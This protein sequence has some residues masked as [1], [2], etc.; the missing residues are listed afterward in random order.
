MI[1]ELVS[2]SLKHAF[3][4]DRNGEIR[5]SLKPVPDRRIELRVSD[6]G[7]GLPSTVDIQET[8]SLGLRLVRILAAQIDASVACFTGGGT[9]FIVNFRSP[10]EQQQIRR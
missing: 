7:I 10:E 3:P 5:V 2:N 6:N 4:G 1:H 8:N 9:A